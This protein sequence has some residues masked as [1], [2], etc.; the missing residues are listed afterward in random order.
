MSREIKDFK[1]NNLFMLIASI[2]GFRKKNE[3]KRIII[4][5]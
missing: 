3:N 4:K 5:I 2:I 1:K